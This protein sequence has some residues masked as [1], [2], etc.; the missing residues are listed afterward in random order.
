MP[1]YSFFRVQ[2]EIVRQEDGT[3]S[4]PVLQLC[5]KKPILD[6]NGE[7]IPPYVEHGITDIV[8]AEH[9]ELQLLIEQATALAVPI[10]ISKLNA[11]I[12]NPISE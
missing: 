11:P 5:W 8:L 2:M 1:E 9:P 10:T 6:N 3:Y 4:R 7:P 12:S